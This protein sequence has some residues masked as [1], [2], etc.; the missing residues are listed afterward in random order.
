M[1]KQLHKLLNVVFIETCAVLPMIEDGQ[2]ISNGYQNM[3]QKQLL[4]SLL[5]GL[6]LK[7]FLLHFIIKVTNIY[8]CLEYP[9]D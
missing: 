6:F 2:N 8:Y 1:T 4:D 5:H 7:Y 3:E 9:I